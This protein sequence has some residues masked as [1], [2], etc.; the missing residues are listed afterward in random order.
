MKGEELTFLFGL[1]AAAWILSVKF[2]PVVFQFINMAFSFMMGIVVAG[3]LLFLFVSVV[4][5]GVSLF[6]RFYSWIMKN[7]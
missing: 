6:K 3:F 5:G 2:F 1:F 4:M 7:H